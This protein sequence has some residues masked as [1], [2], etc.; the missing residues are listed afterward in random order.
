MACGSGSNTATPTIAELAPPPVDPRL[1][2]L[3]DGRIELNIPAGGLQTVAPMQLAQSQGIQAPPCAGFVFLF[4]WQTDS[5][6][7]VR[8]TG[9]LQG[10]TV[11]VSRGPTGNASTDGCMEI[12]VRNEGSQPVTGQLRYVLADASGGA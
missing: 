9:A 6:R 10:T 8:F 12:D 7:E 4:S 5:G 3:G 1:N 11:E 2:V